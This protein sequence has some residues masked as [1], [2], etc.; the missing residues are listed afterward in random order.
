MLTY[1][2]LLGQSLLMLALFL[3]SWGV[4]FGY[5][6]VIW[7]RII[8]SDGGNLI[9][10][11]ALILVGG[12]GYMFTQNGFL[13]ALLAGIAIGAVIGTFTQLMLLIG[14]AIGD[15]RGGFWLGVLYWFI[16]T[17]GVAAAMAAFAACA[18]TAVFS[19]M[20]LDFFM[21]LIT[22]VILM[23]VFYAGFSLFA[24]AMQYHPA[25]GIAVLVGL[26]GGAAARKAPVYNNPVV[27][28]TDGNIHF[29]VDRVDA[30]TLVDSYGNRLKDNH[31]GTCSYY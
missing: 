17:V 11:L 26:A 22:A 2:R 10:G 9:F 19:L 18:K 12:L 13:K 14:T 20:R 6:P 27:L 8:Q 3:L 28:G 24:G 23:S 16:C 30:D 29:V 7:L 5:G 1:L 15:S 4:T 21:T 31:D 25:C